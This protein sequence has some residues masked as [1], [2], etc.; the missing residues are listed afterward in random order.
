M[1]SIKGQK[2]NHA[3]FSPYRDV[4]LVSKETDNIKVPEERYKEFCYN[5][6]LYILEEEL[7]HVCLLE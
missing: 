3:Y 1:L 6:N 2:F 4:I 5:K 7:T